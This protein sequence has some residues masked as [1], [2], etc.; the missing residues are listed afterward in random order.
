MARGVGNIDD[1]CEFQSEGIHF[2]YLEGV[3]KIQILIRLYQLVS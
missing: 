2:S 1:A 3:Q